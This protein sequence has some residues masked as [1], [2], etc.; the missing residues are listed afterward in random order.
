MDEFDEGDIEIKNDIRTNE[1][2]DNV[3][4]SRRL[5][6]IGAYSQVSIENMN[7][8]D[9]FKDTLLKAQSLFVPYGK[10]KRKHSK[11]D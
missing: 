7:N 9:I 3:K 1:I 10:N 2:K 11:S 4:W 6:E 5:E 8:D